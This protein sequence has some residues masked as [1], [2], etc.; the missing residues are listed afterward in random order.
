VLSPSSGSK[1]LTIDILPH[2]YTMS[3]PRRPQREFILIISP[4]PIAARSKT[5]TVFGRSETGIVGS[6]PTRD[7]DVCPRFSVFVFSC[8]GRGLAAGRSP[9]QGV[10]LT[11]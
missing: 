11:V 4:A 9:V 3:Q 5:R 7:K 2:H 1:A 6:N 8:V 10:L